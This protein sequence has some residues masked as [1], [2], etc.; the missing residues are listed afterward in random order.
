MA[1]LLTNIFQISQVRQTS[2]L[3][4]FTLIQYVASIHLC[5][6]IQIKH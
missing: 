3:S 6:N 1:Y 5:H 4:L 2:F